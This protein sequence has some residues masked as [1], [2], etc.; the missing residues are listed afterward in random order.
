MGT[1]NMME[2]KVNGMGINSL[3]PSEL[4]R[5]FLIREDEGLPCSRGHNGDEGPHG[6]GTFNSIMFH[7]PM[8]TLIFLSG[9]YLSSSLGHNELIPLERYFPDWKMRV[10]MDLQHDG[11]EGKWDQGINS[12]WP[13][14][15]ERYFPDWKMRVFMGTWNMMEM[16]VNGMGINSLWPSELERYF[17]DRKMRVF[18]GT[19]N[20]M[21]MKVNGMGINSHCGLVSWRD[22]SLIGR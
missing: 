9:K 16:K 8:K 11:D 17:P 4:E 10:F 13:S 20:M 7:V 19:W 15:L 3:W 14:E 12:L 1:W 18:M 22:T 2:M 5:Y 21:E 6:M